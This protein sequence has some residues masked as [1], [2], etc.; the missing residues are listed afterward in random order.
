MSVLHLGIL[1]VPYGQSSAK[2]SVSAQTTGDV[3]AILE[4][5]Y[6]VYEHFFQAHGQDIAGA[7]EAPLKDHLE[8]MLSGGVS[9]ATSFVAAESEIR[10][11]FVRFI[12]GREMDGLGYPGIPTKAA[13]NGVNHRMKHPTAKRGPRPSF[14]DIGLYEQSFRAEFEE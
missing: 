3:A 1:D 6:H 4:A 13:L 7:L 14:R 5:R 8:D 2:V 12:D 9:A 10:H 11:Q